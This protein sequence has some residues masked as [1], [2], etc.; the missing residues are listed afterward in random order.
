MQPFALSMQLS[1]L[2][3]KLWGGISGYGT[4]FNN[5]YCYISAHKVELVP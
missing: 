4:G 3:P 1:Y 5:H 2:H